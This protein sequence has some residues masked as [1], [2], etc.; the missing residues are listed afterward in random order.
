MESIEVFIFCHYPD[1]LVPVPKII[2]ADYSKFNEGMK[3]DVNFL[4]QHGFLLESINNKTIYGTPY[5]ECRITGYK[6]KDKIFS[7]DDNFRLCD[8]ITNWK[9]YA[10]NLYLCMDLWNDVENKDNEWM[11]YAYQ[12]VMNDA[13]ANANLKLSE[14]QQSLSK[15]NRLPIEYGVPIVLLDE[16]ET[17]NIFNSKIIVKHCV[18]VSDASINITID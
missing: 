3:N 4:I 11:K 13:N 16:K 10:Y 14:L 2:I 8:I 12:Y 17:T 5:Y 7:V 1:D 9:R 18:L 15:M 6:S